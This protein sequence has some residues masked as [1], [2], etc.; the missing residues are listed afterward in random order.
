MS[1]ITSQSN[2]SIFNAL[3][4]LFGRGRCISP[5]KDDEPFSPLFLTLSALFALVCYS[6]FHYLKPQRGSP[7]GPLGLPFVGYLPFL[8][9]ELHTSFAHLARAYG[10]ILKLTLG[11]K[12]WIIISSPSTA[13]EVL[14]DHDLTFANR[15]VP[16][17]AREITYGGSEIV[18][19]SYGPKWRMLRKICVLKMLSRTTLD[20]VYGLRRREVRESIKYLYKRS[21]LPVNVGEEM[22]L[23]AYNVITGMLWAGTMKGDERDTLGA[24]FKNAVGELMELLGMPNISDFFPGLAWFDLQGI[25]KRVK[26]LAGQFDRIFEAVLSQRLGN[27]KEGGQTT[28]EEIKQSLEKEKDFLEFLL[29]LKDGED[30]KTPLTL[31]EIKALLMDMVLNGTETSSN[32]IE[33]IMAEMLNKPHTLQKAQQELDKVVGKDNVVEESHIMKLPYLHAVMKES[34]RLHP[35][36]PVLVPHCPSEDTLISGF[37]IQKDS[38]V[39]INV[40][41]I[42]RDPT[43]WE[44]PD[45]FDPE[46]FMNSNVDYSGNHFNYLPFGSGRRICA[47]IAMAERMVMYSLAT[48]LHSFDWELPKGEKL[49]LSEQFGIVMKKKVALIAI[50]TPRLSDPALY[51]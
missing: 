24:E 13:R 28:V 37:R 31:I 10:P 42:H 50:L 17:A 26:V 23:A 38:M 18:T 43:I 39:Y 7:P 40:W 8:D 15:N 45:E 32:T 46:R 5:P 3:S 14:K 49:D 36:A 20:S 21:G 9:Q 16:V 41:A 6:C 25:Q 48:I 34:L 29:E 51:K 44:N 12:V 30:G 2:S 4:A 19:A 22:F 11:R 1:L 33:F 27:E 47:G 35:P